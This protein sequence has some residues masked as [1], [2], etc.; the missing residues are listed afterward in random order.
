MTPSADPT[1]RRG[2][3]LDWPEERAGRSGDGVRWLQPES[4]I[5]LDFHGDP[6]RARLAVFSDGNHHMA[7]LQCLDWFAR[8]NGDLPVF[9]ATTPPGVV[10]AMLR[11]GGLHL[12]NLTISAT[13]HVFISP[14]EILDGLVADGFMRG[15]IPFVRNQ[16]S[17]I[18][19]QKGNPKGIVGIADLAREDVRLFLSN[20]KTE[21]ASFAA[22]HATL[23]AM[24]PEALA[25]S[26]FP[27]DKIARGEVLFG[28]SIHHREAPQ[29]VADG[30]ADAAMVFYHLALRYLRI[31]P[32]VFD[33]VPLGGSVERPDP[34]SGNVVSLTHAGLVGDGGKW[35]ARLLSFL[36]S[37]TA[38]DIYRR[39]GL[40]PM[41]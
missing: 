8:D 24:A 16:G 21:K 6:A 18:L 20:P 31:F 13:P 32:D 1:L 30:K 38:H 33:A 11:S 2:F 35:G 9:Y 19:T 28:E 25:A 17:V 4:N 29:A 10:A 3:R 37:A 36:S 34:A 39:H 23:R 7:L 5:C 26:G 40:L 41:D 12:G 14:P 22:Y 15:H 27:D